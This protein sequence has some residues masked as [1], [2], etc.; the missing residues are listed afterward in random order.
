M[1]KTY[2][3]IGQPLALIC[4]LTLLLGLSA[5]NKADD[6]TA[7]QKLDSVVVKSGQA[8]AEAGREVKEAVA[9]TEAAAKHAAQDAKASVQKAGSALA[10]KIDDA[11]IS[12]SVKTGLAKDPDLSAIRITVETKDGVVTLQGPATSNLARERATAI[13]A[14]VKGVTSVRNML[15][16]KA[17]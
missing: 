16:V 6:R 15:S 9:S 4:S 1:K 8:A 13:A 17:G 5:C 7:G 3:R 11:A 14:S 12:A 2:A 10:D